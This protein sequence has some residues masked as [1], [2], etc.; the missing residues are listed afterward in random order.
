MPH[1]PFLPTTITI[2]PSPRPRLVPLLDPPLVALG[3]PT[4]LSIKPPQ[5][6]Q[7]ME[8]TTN[9]PTT[10]KNQHNL[11]WS[12]SCTPK[13]H[14]QNYLKII[15]ASNQ[16]RPQRTNHRPWRLLIHRMIKSQTI[17]IQ[18]RV[19]SL[20]LSCGPYVVDKWREIC[21]QVWCHF[22]GR[23]RHCW[24]RWAVVRGYFV[25][26]HNDNANLQSQ[27]GRRATFSN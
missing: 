2:T 1:H 15:H 12:L 23:E 21:A 6:Y 10:N 20:V 24:Q 5:H 17:A 13:N 25:L 18:R 7:T 19:P 27:W 3:L 8:I 26:S 4:A 16:N 14:R 11:A 22:E 9:T